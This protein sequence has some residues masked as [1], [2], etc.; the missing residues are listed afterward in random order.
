M[1]YSAAVVAL[2]LAAVAACGSSSDA[3]VA[4]GPSATPQQARNCA[5]PA[6]WTPVQQLPEWM[7]GEGRRKVWSSLEAYETANGVFVVDPEPRCQIDAVYV[8]VSVNCL[9]W[10]SSLYIPEQYR[11]GP[12]SQWWCYQ[13]LLGGGFVST[14]RYGP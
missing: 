14:P 5:P 9:L 6:E 7:G 8:D 3:S 1:R 11:P 2:V 12:D 10:S 13:E 4:T